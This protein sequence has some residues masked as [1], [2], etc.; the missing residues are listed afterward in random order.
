MERITP[1]IKYHGGK[2]YLAKRIIGLMP[3]HIHYVEPYFGGGAVLLAKNPEGVSEVVNDI[4]G[5]LTNFWRVLQDPKLFK[6]FERRIEATPFSEHEWKL[7][8]LGTG[9]LHSAPN[10]DAAIAFFIRAR[11]SSQGMFDNFGTLSCNRVRRQMNEQA[12]AWLTAIDGLP[13]VH[14]RLKRVVILNRDA[15]KVINTQDST[16]TL[17]YCDPP[18][19]HSTR[20]VRDAY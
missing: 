8:E 14:E 17:F 1:P 19:L 3:E 5:L 2:H 11:Q 12:S 15:T 13:A 10:V 9:P 16:N 20:S 7:A 6:L 18:Y 4:W